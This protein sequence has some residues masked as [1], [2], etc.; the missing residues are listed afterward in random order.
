LTPFLRVPW[1]FLPECRVE[2]SSL[3][4]LLCAFGI[5]KFGAEVFGGALFF[6][7]SA[8]VVESDEFFDELSRY[9]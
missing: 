4:T 9:S 5:L 1:A 6:F 8:P 3:G 7:G 2:E